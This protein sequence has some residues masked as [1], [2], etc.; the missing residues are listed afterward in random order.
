[1]FQ[2]PFVI[3]K[4]QIIVKININNRPNLGQFSKCLQINVTQSIDEKNI[5]K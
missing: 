3:T 1:M 4:I 2:F 5:R